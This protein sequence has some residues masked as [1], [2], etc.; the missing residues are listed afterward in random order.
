MLRYC[1]GL[2]NYQYYGSIFLA[3]LDIVYGTSNESQHDIGN[4]LGPCSTGVTA[5]MGLFRE[6]RNPGLLLR[7]LN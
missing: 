2:D 3:I 7:N 1:R 4:Y 6:S 5:S